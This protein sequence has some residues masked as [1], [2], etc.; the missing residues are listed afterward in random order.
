MLS[1]AEI[2]AR[3][4]S[5]HLPRYYNDFHIVK[6]M[7]LSTAGEVEAARA[8]LADV[9]DQFFIETATWG[10]SRW[11]LLYG[12]STPPDTTLTYEQRRAA[13]KVAMQTKRVMSA[14]GI[15]DI[16]AVYNGMQVSV[17]ENNPAYG[18]TIKFTDM[19]GIPANL[20]EI[21]AQMA[22]LLPAHIAVTYAYMWFLWREFDAK[23]T[24][25]AAFDGLNKTWGSLETWA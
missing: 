13:I 16:F 15:K 8:T 24:T 2:Y 6:A 7:M 11:E 17:T 20:P 21:Q 18:V 3:I 5:K 12:I 4:M 22:A 14:Q 25:W 1:K 10:L 9:F 19:R 23:N